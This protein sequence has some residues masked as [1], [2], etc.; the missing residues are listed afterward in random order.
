MGGGDG[1]GWVL[2]NGDEWEVVRVV[3]VD[4]SKMMECCQFRPQTMLSRDWR[5]FC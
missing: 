3:V 5:T 2:L 4:A 1:G